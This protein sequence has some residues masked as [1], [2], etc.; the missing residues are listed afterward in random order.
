MRYTDL[1]GSQADY[2]QHESIKPMYYPCPRCQTKG[3]RKRVTTR[4]VAHVAALHRR[5]WIVA[6]V[7][8][9][10]ARCDCC[11]YFQAAI[12][13]VPL[14]GRYSFEVRNTVANAL[15]R[16]RMPYLSVIRRMQEDYLLT[17]SLG[18]IH[19]CFLWAHKQINM[20]R[21]W[22]FVHANFSGVLCIDEVH[23]SGRT[24]L[25]ATDPLGDFTV[26]FK[27]VNKNDQPHMDMFLQDLKDRGLR[28]EVVITD[29]S[30]LYKDS[31]QRYWAEVE[32]QLCVFHVIKEVNKLILDGVRSIKNRL[33]RQGNKGRRKGRG[34]PSKKAQKLRQQ[35]GMTKK[36]QATFIWEHQYLIVRKQ[37]SLSKQDKQ[38]LALMLTL[39]PAL[40]VFRQFNQQFYRL[41]QRGITK[42]CARL[43]RT[44][45][46]N[47]PL[48]QANAFLAKAIKKISKDKFDNM[49]V[50]LGW[51]DGQCTNNHVERNNRVFR[52]MQKTRYKRR[53]THTIEKAL[54]LELY[55]RMV[56]HPLYPHNV[57]RLPTVSH[58][59]A[60]LKMAA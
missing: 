1:I 57:R 43:R 29:G 27:V 45:M 22:D 5:S 16:D 40:K 13:G 47:N 46:V 60:T 35:R 11:K 51:D 44:R 23:D 26:S 3:K 52:M 53:K 4:C 49:I 32:H 25:F 41:F 33:K 58:Q 24:I 56:E 37:E 34:R 12:P 30:P 48:Y 6:K 17:L 8:V 9:Y 21:H 59:T 36:E 54:E 28:A 10:Q 7:G 20:E 39:A 2:I 38:D 19:L 42:R 14:R 50:F 55:A 31:L 18:Y 15:I